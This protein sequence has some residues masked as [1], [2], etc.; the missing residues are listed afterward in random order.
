MLVL[1]ERGYVLIAS[2]PSLWLAAK[3]E[4]APDGRQFLKK[5]RF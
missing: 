4:I 5:N 1:A 3:G 2:K